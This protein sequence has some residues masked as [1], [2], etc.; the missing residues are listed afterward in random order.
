MMLYRPTPD[1]IIPLLGKAR[2][3]WPSLL[4]RIDKAERLLTLFELAAEVGRL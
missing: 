4:S 1:E 2:R 3:K